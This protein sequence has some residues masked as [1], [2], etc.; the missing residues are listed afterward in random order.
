MG[1]SCCVCCVCGG[2]VEGGVWHVA[3]CCV[4]GVG[5]EGVWHIAVC[6]GGWGW[7]ERVCGM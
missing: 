3:L 2:G 4:G 6:V 7:V 5:G 1:L